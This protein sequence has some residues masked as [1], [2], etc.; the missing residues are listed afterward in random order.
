MRRI[1]SRTEKVNKPRHQGKQS[2]ASNPPLARD[3]SLRD[4]VSLN[5]EFEEL[6]IQDKQLRLDQ[7][8]LPEAQD[9]YHGFYTARQQPQVARKE[10]YYQLEAKVAEMIEAFNN[11]REKLQQRDKELQSIFEAVP[12]LYLW[13]DENDYLVNLQAGNES[14]ASHPAR[15]LLGKKF[16][17]IFP[18]HIGDKFTRAIKETREGKKDVKAEYI[19][20]YRNGRKD[21]EARF[22]LLPNNNILII[23]HDATEEKETQRVIRQI[24]HKI[25]AVQE[26]ERED[27]AKELHDELG[28]SLVALKMNV[29]LLLDGHRVHGKQRK[30]VM[31]LLDKNIRKVRNLSHILMP[32]QLELFGLSMSL[33]QLVS[34]FNNKENFCVNLECGQL[35]RLVFESTELNVYRLVQES[36]TNIVKHAKATAVEIKATYK[37]GYLGLTVKDNGQALLSFPLGKE[38]GRQIGFCIIKERVR[39]LNGTYNIQSQPGT[40]NI[41]EISIPAINS[42]KNNL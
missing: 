4:F 41:L 33:Q 3:V 10:S 14:I 22:F 6:E 38:N 35:D 42:K 30:K 19:L 34:E 25:I 26:K 20:D 8:K 29:I 12:G 23:S 31:A 40:G 7:I 18:Q 24:P 21:F 37:N 32:P 1:Y 27:I 2:P 13:I 9:K 16:E 28:Q 39:A 17:D 15:G 5:S 36:L 11:V